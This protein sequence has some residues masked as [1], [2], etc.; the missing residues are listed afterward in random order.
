MTLSTDE[1]A[2]YARHVILPEVG[3]GGQMRLKRAQ[4]TVIGAGG[5]GSPALQ[6]LAGAGF[7]RVIVIDDDRIDT[8]NLHRQTLFS[9]DERGAPK[10]ERAVAAIRRINPH[11]DARASVARIDADNA[12]Q[13]LADANVVIDGSDNFAT[14]FAVADATL[15][16]RIPLVSSAVSRF[17]GQVAVFRGWEADKPCY[18]CFVGSDPA[19]EGLTCAE[20]GVLGPVTGVLG[21]M[22]ALEAIRAVT[23]FG[24]DSAGTL[25]LIDLLALRFRTLRL[26]KDPGCP[27]CGGAI[28]RAA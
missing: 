9:G 5:I 18:R 3:G 2:R 26:P 16:R 23:P 7:G 13:L 27:A 12:A 6:Y 17:E 15:A 21:S 19:R 1:L 8:S 4:V 14:R 22:A 20:E 10:A 11:V 24:E 25:L 28:G